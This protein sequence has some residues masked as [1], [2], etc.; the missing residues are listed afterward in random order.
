MRKILLDTYI[1][2]TLTNGKQ[3]LREF[4]KI[5]CPD[6]MR[7][8]DTRYDSYVA[9]ETTRCRACIMEK[10][11]LKNKEDKFNRMEYYHTIQG[12]IYSV[13][14]QQVSRSKKYTWQLPAY[15]K[16][17]LLDWV[18]AQPTANLLFENWEK[19]NYA[20]HL[21]PSID[22]LD[23][24]KPYSLTN[25]QLTTWEY[26]NQK[27][28]EHKLKGLNTKATKPV[29]QYTLGGEFVKKYHS[30]MEA[31][32]QTGIDNAKISACC[33]GYRI[34]KGY[35]KPVHTAGG[36]KWAYAV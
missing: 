14:H 29:N 8:R 12:K 34:A 22:R 17:Q 32:R 30:M 2:G 27:G 13:Y 15:T 18:L 31:Q 33:V 7:V 16:E 1:K 4:A 21:A 26:N 9:S 36:F 23:D 11:P 3:R 5:Q 35:Q 28:K 25:I 6:C 10:K 19:S 20:K 24:Y